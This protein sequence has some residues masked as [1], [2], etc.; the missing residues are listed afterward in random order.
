MTQ[1]FETLEFTTGPDHVATITLNRPQAL[2][3][4]NQTMLDEFV[5]V[6]TRCRE[7][8]AIHAIVLQANKMATS[9][10]STRPKRARRNLLLPSVR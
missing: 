7:D 1:A 10:S 5:Q 3:A 4:F 9:A 8:D 6:W 2:N